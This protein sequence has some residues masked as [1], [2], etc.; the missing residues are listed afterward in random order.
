MHFTDLIC[1]LAD[2]FSRGVDIEEKATEWV[3]KYEQNNVEA[4]RDLVNLVLK[5]CGCELE[6]T[7]HDIE[8]QDNVTGK[9]GDL[10]E[11]Y[12]AVSLRRVFLLAWPSDVFGRI[13]ACRY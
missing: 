4:M 5:A 8:D 11:E 13:T 10:Q 2:V 9:L 12:Q 1:D 6:V 3:A 7:V